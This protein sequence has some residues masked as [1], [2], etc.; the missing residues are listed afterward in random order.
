MTR[1]WRALREPVPPTPDPG[2]ELPEPP[3]WWAFAQTRRPAPEG[4]TSASTPLAFTRPMNCA[5]AARTRRSTWRSAR[6]K[7]GRRVGKAHRPGGGVP[8]FQNNRLTTQARDP[9][10]KPPDPPL[11][12]CPSCLSRPSWRSRTV[13]CSSSIGSSIL[14][15]RDALRMITAPITAP[16]TATATTMQGQA[17]VGFARRAERLVDTEIAVDEARVDVEI[18]Q[19][20]LGLLGASHERCLVL[21][22]FVA[23]EHETDVA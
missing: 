23:I 22:R 7:R 16:T 3:G 17:L 19:P 9:A 4:V 5:A 11:S 20:Q 2:D 18:Q 14:I 8:Q 12:V 21:A 6:P 13:Q 1:W 15:S 10:A